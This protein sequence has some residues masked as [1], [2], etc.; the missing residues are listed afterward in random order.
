MRF[1]P[2]LGAADALERRG[3]WR[4]TCSRPTAVEHF[5]G[6]FRGA[7]YGSPVKNPGG[8]TALSNLYLCGT[9]QGMLGSWARC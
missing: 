1:L 3:P 9:D 5:T 6:H 4:R 2:P 7:I 8:R